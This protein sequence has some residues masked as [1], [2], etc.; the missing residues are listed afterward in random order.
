M[1]LAE[2]LQR[3][4]PD[5]ALVTRTSQ[6]PRFFE[7]FAEGPDYVLRLQSGVISVEIEVA[8]ATHQRVCQI[9]ERVATNFP[10]ETR[11]PGEVSIL[12]WRSKNSGEVETGSKTV[13]V[14]TWDE[15]SHNYTPQTRSQLA[16]LMHL[17]PDND[18]RLRGRVI[19]WHGSPGTG[20]TNAIRALMREWAV[21]CQPELLVDPEIVFARPHY[22]L[23]VMARSARLRE[24]ERGSSWRLLI[25]EDADRYL[26]PTTHLRDNPALDRLLNVADG[27]LGQG[28]NIVILL[29]TNSTVASLHPALT[30]PGRCLAITEFEKFNPVDARKWIGNRAPRPSV[31]KSLAELYELVAGESCLEAFEVDR[32]GQ[33]L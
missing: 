24:D 4:V 18:E 23:E 28:C 6:S 22:L 30:R 26:Q 3:Y 31:P 12:T 11:D 5:D 27:I 1:R 7:V 19:L 2:D 21:W 17:T 32:H 29:T 9:G 16:E 15:I 20:K 13:A 25:A 8:A 10:T 14:P 33:Y